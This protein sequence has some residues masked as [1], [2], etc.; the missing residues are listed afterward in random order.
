MY[1]YLCFDDGTGYRGQTDHHY[2]YEIHRFIFLNVFYSRYPYPWVLRPVTY[3]LESY[4]TDILAAHVNS[5]DE[6]I[7]SPPSQLFY[8]AI[9][10][11]RNEDD[12]NFAP[13]S[14][15]L[16]YF[17][18]RRTAYSSEVFVQLI[19]ERG[20]YQLKITALTCPS[21][22]EKQLS[23]GNLT[24]MMLASMTCNPESNSAVKPA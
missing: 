23:F 8:V 6:I 15:G 7:L 16:I 1:L 2:G 13:V 21:Q 10:S 4:E 14:G 18:V 19:V 24:R 11:I 20:T 9:A 22:G 5:N 3:V 17:Y 12:R